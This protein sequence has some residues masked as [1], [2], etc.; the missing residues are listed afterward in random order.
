VTEA[1]GQ[2]V[3]VDSRPGANGIIAAEATR[4]AA[5]D[6]HTMFMAVL[7]THAT[8][9]FL[10]SKLPYDPI[11]D[12]TPVAGLATTGLVL[13]VHPDI[14][15][16]T[17]PELVAYL[18]A[19]PGKLNYSAGTATVQ[20]VGELFKNLAHVDVGAIPYK[21]T[22]PGLMA[23]AA[24]EVAYTFEP[25][26]TALAQMKAGRVRGLAVGSLKRSQLLPE[27]PTIDEA[28]VRGFEGYSWLTIVMPAGVPKD[29][30]TKMQDQILRILEMPDVKEKMLAGGLEPLP[31]NA[32]QVAELF[33]SEMAKWGKVIRQAGLKIE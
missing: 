31:L 25:T 13:V 2:S 14:P 1:W 23:V 17:V 29:I 18:R 3:I 16:K 11:K 22:A 27:L 6:G 20:M 28:G 30:A 33:K 9:P 8:N 5:P 21:G 10:Y 26:I 4:N 12:F 19:N 32:E 7:S 15:A 24:G